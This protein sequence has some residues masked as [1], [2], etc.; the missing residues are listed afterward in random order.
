MNKIPFT[1]KFPKTK[2][3]NNEVYNF[4]NITK[5]SKVEGSFKDEDQRQRYIKFL[6]E[7]LKKK[8]KQTTLIDQD[9][10]WY[11]M[12]DIENR[13]SIDYLEGEYDIEDEPEIVNGGKYFYKK[14]QELRKVWKKFS[15]Q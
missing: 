12:D 9:I 6:D 5:E 2:Y 10:F 4:W 13:A 15:I 3:T 1:I 14:G 8:I 7:F 11:F